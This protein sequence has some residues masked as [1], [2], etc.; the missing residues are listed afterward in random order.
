V[1][2]VELPRS[3]NALELH[4]KALEEYKIGIAPGPIFSP[5]QRYQNFIRLSCG[6][7]WSDRIEQAL[8]TLGR[9]AFKQS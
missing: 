7:T 8:I 4:R 9:L 3:V 6:S 5:K 2:W 1:L